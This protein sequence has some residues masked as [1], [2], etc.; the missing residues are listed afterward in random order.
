MRNA[1]P[2]SLSADEFPLVAVILHSV[3]LCKAAPKSREAA[4]NVLL[5]SPSDVA[6]GKP[7]QT[8]QASLTVK[9]GE[10]GM[11]ERK[12]ACRCLCNLHRAVEC[13]SLF[14]TLGERIMLRK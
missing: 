9:R 5:L 6:N 12:T 13:I 1:V 2:W 7:S 8:E 10:N 4:Q 3:M 14:P 11:V